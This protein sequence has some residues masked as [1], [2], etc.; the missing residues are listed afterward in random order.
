MAP[1]VIRVFRWLWLAQLASNVGSWMQSVGAQ[2]MLV[3]DEHA[4]LLTALVSAASLLPVLLLSLPAGVLADSLDRRWLLIFANGF[5]ACAAGVLALVTWAGDAGPAVVLV[6]TFA[7]GCGAA[8]GS[9]AWQ[10]IQPDLVPRYLIPSASAITSAN[11]N[12]ARAVGPAVAGALVAW[13]GPALVFGVNAVSFASVIVALALWRDAPRSRG[14]VGMG[15]A[16]A[17]GLRYVRNAP[18]VRRI[19]FRAA[20]FVIP[21]SALWA[22][23]AV[24]AHGVMG[25]QSSGYGVMLGALGLG[26]V[27]GALILPW[28]RGRLHNNGLLL[29]ATAVYGLAMMAVAFARSLPLVLTLL[30]AAGVGWVIVLSVLNTAMM[31]TL[32]A[33]VR[34]RSLAVYSIVFMGGQG[35]GSAVWGAVASALGPVATLAVGAALVL[36]GLVTMAVWPLYHSTG[37][38]DREIAAMPET[39]PDDAVPA[40]AGPV[41]IQVEYEV[42]K[43]HVA[44]FERAI[45]A[46]AT[47]RRRT[48]ATSW[49]LWQDVA[50]LGS[51]VEQYTLPT[52]GEHIAQREERITGYD[53]ELERQALAL[54][55]PN[56]RVR[57]LVRPENMPRTDRGIAVAD[58]QNRGTVA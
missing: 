25:Q 58:T 55:T 6:L 9:P 57:H 53:R 23:L 20:V 3:G 15:P 28:L 32:P 8:L 4:A 45:R 42:S 38:L 19:T 54:A 2:W 14:A 13:A 39:A 40:A 51:F 30:L 29:G 37:A 50:D 44:G 46:L 26:A 33:W 35:V 56:P 43:D 49:D 41:L 12:I 5:M 18:G 34:A 21:A 17:S 24:V 52:W 22:L 16:I 27:V 7:L 48:G 1:L 10:A 11:I 47:S 31:L 36:A